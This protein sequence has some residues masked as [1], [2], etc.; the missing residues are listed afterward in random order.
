MPVLTFDSLDAMPEEFR[1]SAKENA[2]KKFEVNLSLTAKVDEFRGNNTKLA[3]ERDSLAA[4]IASIKPLVGEDPAAFKARL[5]EL[6]GLEQ[7]VKD[8]AL[9]GS[10]VV[11]KE[12]VKR[13]DTMRTTLEAQ[14]A[15]QATDAKTWKGK[16]EALDRDL[17]Q[18]RVDNAINS[19]CADP[20]IGLNPR[21]TADVLRRA[22]S[23]FEV[24]PDG[25]LI[26]KRNGEVI[27]GEDGVAPMTPAEWVKSLRK[28]A[29]YY[30]LKSS[31]GGANG[32]SG[33]GQAK[34]G[35]MSEA[36]FNKLTPLERLKIANRGGKAA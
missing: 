25:S 14:I 2:D 19:V 9:Q 20:A 23:V 16:Y 6:V 21:A 35:G 22:R 1:G 34:F 5:D 31:G 32:D 12:V 24:Q 30:F 7:K 33:A 3:N 29:D 15:A 27:R 28:E 17:K 18:A 13:T 10:D 11:E 8:G 26:P 36:E 4:Y